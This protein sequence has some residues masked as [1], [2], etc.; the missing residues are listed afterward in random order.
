[1]EVSGH[2]LA[3]GDGIAAVDERRLT[4]LAEED[5]ELILVETA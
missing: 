5:S 4:L 2:R 3:V 1:V